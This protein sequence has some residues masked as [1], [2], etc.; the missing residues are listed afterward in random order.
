VIKQH[1]TGSS[2]RAVNIIWNAAGNYDFEPPFLAFFPNG[3]EDSYFNMVIGLASKWLDLERINLF[4][5]SLGLSNT[6]QEAASVLWL[7]IENCVYEKELSGRPI[8]ERLRKER[9]QDFY[10]YA[11]SLSRQQMML[12]SMKVFDQEEARWGKVL[13]K[14]TVLSP[15]AKKLAEALE[16]PGDLDTDRLIAKMTEIAEDSF[17]VR[18][19]KAESGYRAYAVKGLARAFARTLMHR[20]IRNTDL[21]I[22]RKGTGTGDRKGAVHL[23]HVFGQ[24]HTSGSKEKD[25]QYIE[26]CFGSC[27]Y[28]DQEMRILENA[29]CTGPDSSCS[30]W[31]TRVSAGHGGSA[32]G[33]LS[34]SASAGVPAPVRT[35]IAGGESRPAAGNTPDAAAVSA[36]AEAEMSGGSTGAPGSAADR[37]RKL[38][39]QDEENQRLRN[40]RYYQD[41]IFRIRESIRDLSAQTDTIFSS[42]LRYLP[43]RSRRGKIHAEEAWR[44]P[45]LSD[46]DVFL[47]DSD[48]TEFSVTV[49]LLL[50]AS[51]SRMNIQE[52]IASQALIIARS[53]ESCGI[54]VRVTAFRSLR[55]YTVLQRLK[56]YGDRKCEGI[57]RYYAGGWN[58]DGLCLKTM[59]YL[60]E[61]EKERISAKRILL[62]LTDANPN[63]S[64]QI[65]PDAD[66]VFPR[67]YEGDV[68]VRDAAEGVKL[69]KKSGIRTAAIYFGPTTHLDNVHQIYGQDYVRIRSLNQFSDAVGM[70][71]K[72]SLEKI[73]PA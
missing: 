66:H 57:F 31:L 47:S 16:F 73:G 28:T 8:L 51:Q 17:R 5:D 10:T 52:S 14:K 39:A 53:F 46:P 34:S 62:V 19:G 32:G 26:D 54:P 9:A 45:V 2:R 64:M 37:R 43:K 60:M 13:G 20:E 70:L 3:D 21:L 29:L 4:F 11:A 49:D 36:Q 27:M 22:L 72:R 15:G 55:G 35:D 33:S 67:E 65:P 24:E 56:E 69:L 18:P 7:G 30:L 42:Y 12:Q 40:I 6:A 41:N 59:N 50:D 38:L 63:D 1:Y 58:R 68:A 23:E 48:I 44:L 71:L 25:R 61:D